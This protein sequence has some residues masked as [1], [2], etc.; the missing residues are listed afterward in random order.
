M[1]VTSE[2]EHSRTMESSIVDDRTQHEIY[3]YPFLKSVMAGLA[4]VMC[5]SIFPDHVTGPKTDKLLVLQFVMTF[6]LCSI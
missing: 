1:N 5:V 6:P 3:A 4:S 2:Q